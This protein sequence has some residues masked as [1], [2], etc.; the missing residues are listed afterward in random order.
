MNQW[1]IVSI[2]VCTGLENMGKV[3]LEHDHRQNTV[4]AHLSVLTLKTE[5]SV[6][7]SKHAPAQLY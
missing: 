5:N 3:K 2:Q 4:V 1:A 7:Q 6:G